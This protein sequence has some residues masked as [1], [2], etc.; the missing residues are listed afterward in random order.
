MR[1][2]EKAVNWPEDL[3][4]VISYLIFFRSLT[5]S[6]SPLH[7]DF[8]PY[9]DPVTPT[10]EPNWTSRPLFISLCSASERYLSPLCHSDPL[11]PYHKTPDQLWCT[12]CQGL[13]PLSCAANLPPGGQVPHTSLFTEGYSL[14]PLIPPQEDGLCFLLPLSDHT[15]FTVLCK[16]W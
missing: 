11:L 16:V 10:A 2:L 1:D 5:C 12:C 6:F 14:R 7:E 8:S 9:E 15:F 3:G 4:K 13:N